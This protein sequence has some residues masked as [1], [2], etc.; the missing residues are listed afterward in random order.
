MYQPTVVV[1]VGTMTWSSA[2]RPSVP[3]LVVTPIAGIV[4]WTGRDRVNAGMAITRGAVRL[5]PVP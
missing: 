4:S 5:V 2:W 1:F 3:T